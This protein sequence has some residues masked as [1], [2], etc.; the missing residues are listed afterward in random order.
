MTTAVL[1]LF[2]AAPD[3]AKSRLAPTP[4]RHIP[5][6]DGLRGMAILLV[7]LY[8][9]TTQGAAEGVSPAFEFGLGNRGVDLFFVLSGFLIT[10][11][12]YDAK[13]EQHYFRNFYMRRSLRI[14]PLYYGALL[15][16]LVVLPWFSSAAATMFAQAREHQVWLWLYGANVLNAYEGAW[17]L[18]R[19]DHFWS[20]A[21]EEHFYLVWPLVVY[22]CSRRTSLVICT[23][24]IVVTPLAR[25]GWL[26]CG[27]NSTAVEV[28]TLFRLDALAVGAWIALAMRSPEPGESRPV[29][30]A[31][32]VLALEHAAAV[33]GDHQGDAADV[34]ARDDVRLLVRG[35]A[36]V[37]R[38]VAGV[39]LD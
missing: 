36:R 19:F 1:P 24:M 4:A 11:I 17:C 15:V 32:N 18:G 38:Y 5:A 21:V 29:R 35:R 31:G 8:R 6:L 3:V 30:W 28:F 37:C 9:F 16:T 23:L 20:L 12:L 27:G 14:W 25:I 7:T 33:A 10:G 13:S 39:A 26:A 34:S 22:F 2:E